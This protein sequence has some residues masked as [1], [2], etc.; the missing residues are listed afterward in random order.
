MQLV[1]IFLAMLAFSLLP[2]FTLIRA[3]VPRLSKRLTLAVSPA[4]TFFLLLVLA[5]LFS[6]SSTLWLG[7]LGFFPDYWRWKPATV[8]PL[9]TL[10]SVIFAALATWR[11]RN[12]GFNISW[13]FPLLGAG[14]GGIVAGIAPMLA[15]V[16]FYNPAQRWD[17]SFH[18]NALSLLRRTQDAHPLYALSGMYG[19]GAKRYYPDGWHVFTV[20]FTGSKS[21]V[22]AANLTFVLLVCWWIIGICALVSLI[23]ISR[24]AG[25]MVTVLSG[26]TFCFPADSLARY[27]QWPNGTGLALVPGTTALILVLGQML[28]AYLRKVAGS[29]LPSE[30]A[31]TYL[32][33]LGL[34]LKLSSLL[35]V[36]FIC[37]FMGIGVVWVHP[38]VFFNLLALLFPPL[39]ALIITHLWQAVRGRKLSSLAG[40]LGA[41]LGTLIVLEVA[42]LNPSSLATALFDRKGDLL[43]SFIRP[44]FPA[45]FFYQSVPFILFM[46][47]MTVLFIFGIVAIF[48]GQAPKWLLGSWAVCAFLV[49]VSSLPPTELKVLTGPWYSDPRRLMALLQLPL[50]LLVGVGLDFFIVRGSRFLKS[51]QVSR[52]GRKLALVSV[53]SLS[54]IIGI[55]ASDSRVWALQ[56]VF[57]PNQTGT[58]GFAN[59]AELAL[60]NRSASTLPKD[61][62]ILGDPSIGTVYFDSIAGR[63]VVFPALSKS[64]WD[65]KRSRLFYHL[66]D[67]GK[68]PQI[69]QALNNLKVTHFYT[70]PDSKFRGVSRSFEWPGFYGVPIDGYFTEVD[71]G[72]RA[73]LYRFNGCHP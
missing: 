30:P 21:V 47:L 52:R 19:D 8:F 2:G 64:V 38:A 28:L 39:T 29:S 66:N 50:N 48:N 1:A 49:M 63:K 20:L 65:S 46:G 35:T 18:Y 9:I 4:L 15:T 72:G 41:C 27:V 40:W 70:R 67:L 5:A 42:F 36:F 14:L 22:P 51:R 17:P 58:D 32:K 62:V 33:P 68:D 56:S 73:V 7:K 44:L 34:P 37:C 69:C 16:N 31:A 12:I 60:I 71:R 54:L 43:L 23:G 10:L 61:A 25:L 6:P 13:D 53:L 26:F 59:S 45:P 57:N 3:L 24:R 11:R 55:S